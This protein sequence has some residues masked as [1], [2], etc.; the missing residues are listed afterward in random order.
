MDASSVSNLRVA[1]LSTAA[2]ARSEAPTALLFAQTTCGASVPID[3]TPALFFD[4]NVRGLHARGSGA[5]P[6]AARGSSRTT[7]RFAEHKQRI[8]GF[9][10]CDERRV[11]VSVA[12]K[13]ELVLWKAQSSKSSNDK[14][15]A[16]PTL[17]T[18]GHLQIANIQKVVVF[19][20]GAFKFR[21]RLDTFIFHTAVSALTRRFFPTF[22]GRRVVT[23]D[24]EKLRLSQ[25][26]GAGASLAHASDLPEPPPEGSI[27][28]L[29]V[30]PREG[31]SDKGGEDVILAATSTAEIYA[32]RLGNGSSTSPTLV[33]KGTLPYDNGSA[34]APAAAGQLSLVVRVDNGSSNV[35]RGEVLG[36]IT[37]DGILE[38][39]TPQSLP[40]I[41]TQNGHTGTTGSA[42][43]GAWFKSSRV[44]TGRKDVVL[45]RCSSFKK[46]ALSE[47]PACSV[48]LQGRKATNLVHLYS[49]E[50][51]SR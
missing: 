4:G 17:R 24:G 7:P 14:G 12:Q 38:L 18:I 51:Q 29:T 36:T 13:S 27:A 31:S 21:F 45:A 40:S 33:F 49:F 39:W 11:L 42:R 23:W 3:L 20:Q 44:R 25:A 15:R 47:L 43:Q 1:A 10:C 16:R 2:S 19:D 37:S 28:V 32:W 41:T 22:S 34:S 5:D 6:K 35:P 48:S 46:N 30:L 26:S 50:D 9:V 8:R